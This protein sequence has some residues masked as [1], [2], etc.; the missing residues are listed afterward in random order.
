MGQP[1]ERVKT[2]IKVGHTPPNQVLNSFEE[3]EKGQEKPPQPSSASGKRKN[4]QT[5]SF[6]KLNKK[7]EEKK[8]IVGRN[9]HSGG[10]GLS[11]AIRE[12]SLV[13]NEGTKKDTHQR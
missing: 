8:K 9:G 10:C 13:R 7:N 12:E 4:N 3:G 6:A 11:K 5:W 1:D 2:T